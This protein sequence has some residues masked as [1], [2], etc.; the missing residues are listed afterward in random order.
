M[1]RNKE[2]SKELQ[3]DSLNNE[4]LYKLKNKQQYT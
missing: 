1:Y 4:Y 2:R 3:E